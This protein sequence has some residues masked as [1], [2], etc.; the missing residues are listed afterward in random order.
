MSFSLSL[1]QRQQQQLRQPSFSDWKQL[2]RRRRPCVHQRTA[3]SVAR[4]CL[5]Q[6]NKIIGYAHPTKLF[7]PQNP[8][9]RRRRQCHTV[10]FV[11]WILTLTAVC[12]RTN[13]T[14]STSSFPLNRL[15]SSGRNNWIKKKNSARR[16]ELCCA[17]RVEETRGLFYYYRVE[18]ACHGVCVCHMATTC[19]VTRR[20]A[21][22]LP[23]NPLYAT[24]R[25]SSLSFL[26]PR[27]GY[28]QIMHRERAKEP[29]GNNWWKEPF[30]SFFPF[31]PN[32]IPWRGH[33]SFFLS[34]LL[35]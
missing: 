4:T 1:W 32:P 19:H 34:S 30:F 27:R 24:S 7:V 29:W 20:G 12:K 2:D 21:T 13:Q 3:R 22:R 18:M 23:S 17:V 11:W 28:N 33:I 8:A 16:V 15:T 9:W 10:D 14:R 26:S 25:T 35:L 6:I 5:T 31:R